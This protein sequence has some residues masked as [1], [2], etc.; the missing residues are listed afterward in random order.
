MVYPFWTQESGFCG[1]IT[2]LCACHYEAKE[3]EKIAYNDV[4]SLYPFVNKH[5][6]YPTGHPTIMV[7]P[8]NQNI[9]GYFGLAKVGV[10]A[11]EKLFHPVLPVR[12]N[13]KVTFRLCGK[14]AEDQQSFPRHEPQNTCPHSD[15]DR[16]IRGVWCTPELEKAVEMGY[17][18]LKIHEVWYFPENQ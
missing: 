8:V 2:G 15:E 7:N 17:K 12:I 1:G 16:M 5:G 10:L 4:T 9:H 13:G 6:I 14:C 11:P 18:I 3:G